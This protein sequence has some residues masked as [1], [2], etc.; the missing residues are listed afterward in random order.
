[1]LSS[2]DSKQ[3]RPK[4]EYKKYENSIPPMSMLISPID[5]RIIIPK[6]SINVPIVRMEDKYM[7]DDIWGKFEKEVQLALKNGVIHYP[8]T[9]V[10]GR[11]G[12]AFFTG[13]SSYY[14]W[15]NGRY[16]EVFVNLDKLDVGDIYYVYYKQ[17][18]YTYM[19]KEVKEVSPDKVSVLSQPKNKKLS[20]L[21]TCWPPGTTL[22]R[23][24]VISEDITDTIGS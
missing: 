21:M 18:K 12:N 10:P 8:G 6:I 11:N 13:H 1:M 23:L 4:Q 9:S 17:K 7:S 3:L 16:K 15:D 2:I 22:K 19:V 14:P 24:I 5:Y 20:T